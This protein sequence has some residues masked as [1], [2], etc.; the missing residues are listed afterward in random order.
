MVQTLFSRR[1]LDAG[2]SKRVL[3]YSRCTCSQAS[4]STCFKASS[5]SDLS[6]KQGYL[7]RVTARKCSRQQQLPCRHPSHC[8]IELEQGF[9]NGSPRLFQSANDT[10]LFLGTRINVSTGRQQQRWQAAAAMAGS[11]SNNTGSSSRNAGSSSSNA[12][13]SSSSNAG[14]RQQQC[15]QAATAMQAGGN[16]NAGRRQQQCRQ[17][18]AAMQAGG[19][20][21]AGNSNASSSSNAGSSNQ[22]RSS[23]NRQET[24]AT[25]R[26]ETAAATRQETTAAATANQET[27]LQASPSLGNS[28]NS[29]LKTSLFQITNSATM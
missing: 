16:S 9:N 10:T 1:P 2:V 14:R 24:A 8:A 17:A 4:L 22:A 7:A 15:R 26:Q 11:S 20:S 25:T 28:G 6:C 21:N 23:N 18:A 5:L 13:G 12:G 29:P 19:S 27:T 3:L